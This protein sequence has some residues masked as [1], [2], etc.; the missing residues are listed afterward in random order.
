[1]T[2]KV[3]AQG[4]EG[5]FKETYTKGEME[6]MVNH[7]CSGGFHSIIYYTDT[8]ALYD[9]FVEDIWNALYEDAESYGQNIMELM[10]S[11]N[12]AKDVGGD[13]QFKNLLVWYMCERIAYN[14]IES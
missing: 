6:D 5:W 2:D 7:G 10:A 3:K 13:E 14:I 11:F 4:F 1:M 9:E 12:G 8:V